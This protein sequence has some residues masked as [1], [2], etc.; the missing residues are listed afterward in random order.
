MVV[1]ASVQAVSQTYRIFWSH[2]WLVG[3]WYT[4]LLLCFHPSVGS[5]FVDKTL[6]TSCCCI[7]SPSNWSLWSTFWLPGK[8]WHFFPHFPFCLQH[9]VFGFFTHLQ[10]PACLCFGFLLRIF[11]SNYSPASPFR[12]FQNHNF[13]AAINMGLCHQKVVHSPIFFI[14][15]LPLNTHCVTLPLF[16]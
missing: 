16:V 4:V 12:F 6:C 5:F 14:F 13:Y 15:F 7:F 10:E 9:P 11:Y 3:L 8:T 2:P 1:L